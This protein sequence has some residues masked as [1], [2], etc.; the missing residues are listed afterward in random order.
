MKG[1]VMNRFRIAAAA[2]AAALI[3]MVCVVTAGPASAGTP[4]GTCTSSYKPY[5]LG[6]LAAFDP[7][8]RDIFSVVDTNGNGIICFKPYPNGSH[9][10]HEGNVVDDKAAPHD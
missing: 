9:N 1:V 7:A 8:I 10:G 3:P 2:G 5:T 6:E 4:T